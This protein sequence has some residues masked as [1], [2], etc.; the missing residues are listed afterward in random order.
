MFSISWSKIG[1]KLFY[2]TLENDYFKIW[3]TYYKFIVKRNKKKHYDT[4]LYL[5]SEVNWQ[6]NKLSAQDE[7]MASPPTYSE[8]QL[9][10]IKCYKFQNLKQFLQN[11]IAWYHLSTICKKYCLKNFLCL[12]FLKFNRK[13]AKL[14]YPKNRIEKYSFYIFL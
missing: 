8:V 1:P 2:L 11:N 3:E 12:D 5:V 7:G 4:T 14:W 6:T 13:L 10:L 9:N